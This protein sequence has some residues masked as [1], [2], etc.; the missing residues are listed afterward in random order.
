MART[1]IEELAE[2]G[3]LILRTA[4]GEVVAR[5]RAQPALILMAAN[6]KPPEGLLWGERFFYRRGGEYVEGLL[7]PVYGS[8]LVGAGRENENTADEGPLSAV[9]SDGEAARDEEKRDE[10]RPAEE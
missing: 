9:S 4:D 7:A 5:L 2:D 3:T 8:E 10:T 1:D 6:G